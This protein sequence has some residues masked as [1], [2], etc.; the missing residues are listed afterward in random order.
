[1]I[2]SAS[3]LHTLLR[4]LEDSG[5]MRIVVESQHTDTLEITVKLGGQTFGVSDLGV[6]T[7]DRMR[8]YPAELVGAKPDWMIHNS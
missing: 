7:A 3:Q 4:L 1:M 6:R 8:D 5:Y 2:V